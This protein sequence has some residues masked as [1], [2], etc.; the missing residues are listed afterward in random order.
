VFSWQSAV[1]QGPFAALGNERA[2]R[3]LALDPESSSGYGEY[4]V[5]GKVC[6]K[7]IDIAPGT[8]LPARPRNIRDLLGRISLGPYH[9]HGYQQQDQGE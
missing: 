1:C 9:R 7:S 5:V 8:R 3:R 6:Q 2:H 4:H